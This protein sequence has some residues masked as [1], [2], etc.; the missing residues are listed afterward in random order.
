MSQL[1]LK[2][3]DRIKELLSDV[4]MYEGNRYLI[5]K[6]KNLSEEELKREMVRI[7]DCAQSLMQE[8]AKKIKEAIV[9]LDALTKEFGDKK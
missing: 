5:N 3:I 4:K 6:L 1:K 8:E 9:W 2:S 7:D